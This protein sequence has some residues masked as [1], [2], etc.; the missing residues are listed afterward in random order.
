PRRQ[1]IEAM[2]REH[3]MLEQAV[4]RPLGGRAERVAA[5][6]APAR[7]HAQARREPRGEPGPRRLA[8]A[9]DVVGAER[10]GAR[11]RDDLARTDAFGTYHVSCK[12]ETT[13]AGFA[14]RLAAR[15]GVA[16]GWSVV[17]SDALGAPAKRP[18][19]CLF[20]HRMLALHG[21]DQ[22]PTWEA[23]QDEYLAE[24]AR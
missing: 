6:D 14:A 7:R 4:R 22:L 9:A 17:G 12:G 10:V 15:L 16:P 18:P 8:L 5:D 2:Q 19:N 20:Q 21:L 3:A 24:E 1:L 13:W 11:Q 23:A